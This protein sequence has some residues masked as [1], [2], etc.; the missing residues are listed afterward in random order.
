M[1]V[2]W[3]GRS[4]GPRL[5]KPKQRGWCAKWKKLI[6]LP[7]GLPEGQLGNLAGLLRPRVHTSQQPNPPGPERD[8]GVVHE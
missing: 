2:L 8:G 6:N 1:A 4:D 7:A 3:C 5:A